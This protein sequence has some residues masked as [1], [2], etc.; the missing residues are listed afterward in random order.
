MSCR[1]RVGFGAPGRQAHGLLAVGQGFRILLLTSVDGG[2]GEAQADVGGV[3]ADGLGVIGQGAGTV[4]EPLFHG[5][6]GAQS[7][8]V[9]GLGLQRGVQVL[10]GMREVAES[11]KAERAFHI[12]IG[13]AGFVPSASVKSSMASR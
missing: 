13:G 2:A 6:S 10:R 8:D 9:A 12:E 1:A 4:A 5:A 11:G 7:A 3:Q